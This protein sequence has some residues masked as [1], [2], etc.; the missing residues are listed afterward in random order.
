MDVLVVGVVV[1]DDDDGVDVGIDVCVWLC[2]ML[3]VLVGRSCVFACVCMSPA[4]CV[5]AYM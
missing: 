5:C 2:V 1:V 4:V 3:C